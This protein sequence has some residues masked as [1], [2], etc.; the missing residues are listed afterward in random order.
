MVLIES[1]QIDFTAV[2]WIQQGVSQCEF[3][4]ILE[5]SDDWLPKTFITSL[6]IEHLFQLKVLDVASKDIIIIMLSF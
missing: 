2:R 4:A 1:D 5:R 3:E 6:K